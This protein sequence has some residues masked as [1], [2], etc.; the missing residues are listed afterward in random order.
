[1]KKF[2]SYALIVLLSFLLANLSCK[3]RNDDPEPVYDER[4]IS[5]NEGRSSGAVLAV[6]GLD[7]I[8]IAWQ[9]EESGE[10]QVYYRERY[11]NGEWGDI[12]DIADSECSSIAIDIATNNGNV[13]VVWEEECGSEREIDF[14]E[15][16]D[17]E[18]SEPI[19]ISGASGIHSLPAVSVDGSG[20]IYVSWMG[21]FGGISF[22]KRVGEVWNSRVDIEGTFGWE[23]PMMYVEGDGK[24]HIVTD[25]GEICYF[26]SLDGGES[27]NKEMVVDSAFQDTYYDWVADVVAVDNKVYVVWTRSK[28]GEGMLGLYMSIK[29]TNDVWS[30]PEKLQ[31]AKNSPHYARI[32]S[33]GEY[34]YLTWTEVINSQ[35]EVYLSKKEIGGGWEDPVNVSNTSTNSITR[36]YDISNGVVYIAWFE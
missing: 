12:L 26:Y 24:V 5:R 3:K 22:R 27:W 1:M 18:W 34:L 7:N 23:N 15:R 10:W 17:G 32:K 25:H 29:D 8:H 28:Y 6:D 30:E 11:S 16:V 20:D 35:I 4:N 33:D 13:Y 31:F 36:G 9:D 21:D 19:S 2:Y 14:A